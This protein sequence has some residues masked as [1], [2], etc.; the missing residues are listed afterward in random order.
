MI[1]MSLQGVGGVEYLERV[2]NSHPAAYMA[3]LGRVLPTTLAGGVDL[4]IQWP[5][6]GPKI[7]GS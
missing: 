4:N 6:S 5:V 2:A 7:A 3:L 1:L